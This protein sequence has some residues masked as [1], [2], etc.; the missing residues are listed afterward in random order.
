M[1]L[2][3]SV[4]VEVV[5]REVRALLREHER[6]RPPNAGVAAGDE[7]DLRHI[8]DVSVQQPHN[9]KLGVKTRKECIRYSNQG[10]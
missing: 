9:C 1:H 7:S 6:C 2:S 3:I 5:D 10:L 4:L 8:A